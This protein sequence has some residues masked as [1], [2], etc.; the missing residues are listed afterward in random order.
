[1]IVTG[2]GARSTPQEFLELFEALGQEAQIRGWHV[3]S[4]HADGAD[5]AFEL[6]AKENCIVYLPWKSFNSD[7]PVLGESVCVD[8]RE[9]VMEMIY[10]HEPYAMECN[11]GVKRIKAR[12]VYQVLGVDLQKPSDVVVC[13]TPEG[14][15]TGG[16][17]LAMKIA[18][19]AG[20]PIINVG[21]WDTPATLKRVIEA[22]ES[23]T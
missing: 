1:M 7:K 21:A 3:R 5:Y 4:G 14:K 16:T 12:N 17:G 6:G 8:L 10:R 23:I 9:D 19:K 18:I 20:V 15:I 22:I 2:I 13:W 11:I